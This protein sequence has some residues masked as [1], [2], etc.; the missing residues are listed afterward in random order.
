MAT[1]E[2]LG[3]FGTEGLTSAYYWTN[4]A[5]RSPAFWAFRAFRNFDGEGG[6]F[7]DRSVPARNSTAL[8]S[9]FGSIDAEGKH[10]VAILLNFAA[11]SSVAARI[12]FE[13]CGSVSAA[14]GFNYAGGEDGFKKVEVSANGTT[15]E[16]LAAPY[17]ITVLDLTLGPLAR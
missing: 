1:A 8:T 15:V 16:T 14:R 7:L 4:P 10:A 5:D 6:R 3:R 12:G 2:A 13:G 9:L 11:F 17:S